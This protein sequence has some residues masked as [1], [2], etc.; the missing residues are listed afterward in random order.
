[1]LNN[2]A[3]TMTSLKRSKETKL[4]DLPLQDLFDRMDQHKGHLKLLQENDMCSQEEKEEIMEM[5]KEIY[6]VT[7]CRSKSNKPMS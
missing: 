5:V 7:T 2:D 4:E 6:N 3:T 1:M